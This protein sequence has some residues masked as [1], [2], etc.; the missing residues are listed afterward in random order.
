MPGIA[1][2]SNRFWPQLAPSPPDADAFPTPSTQI[3]RLGFTASTA[4]PPCEARLDH[5]DQVAPWGSFARSIPIT[6]VN[7]F[8]SVASFCRPGSQRASEYPGHAVG[9]FGSPAPSIDVLQV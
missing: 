2:A 4:W 8:E 7:V 6:F 3:V 1:A 9:S 5:A